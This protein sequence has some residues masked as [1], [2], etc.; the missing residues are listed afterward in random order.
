MLLAGDGGD[1]AVHCW[2]SGSWQPLASTRYEGNETEH[3]FALAHSLDRNQMA[4]GGRQ[5]SVHLWETTDN[6]LRPLAE[7]QG[8]HASRIQ[9][10]AFAPG[11]SLL[12]SAD[13][14]GVIQLWDLEAR[15]CAAHHS[16]TPRPGVEPGL[17]ARRAAIGQRG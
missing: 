3:M 12:A 8:G 16:G 10:L 7:L 15:Q 13:K 11:R 14:L 9:A 6:G 17:V 4:G 2:R 1:G 5:N